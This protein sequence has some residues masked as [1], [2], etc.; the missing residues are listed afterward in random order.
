[1][2]SCLKYY[3]I[4]DKKV[5]VEILKGSCTLSDY[6]DFKSDQINDKDFNPYFN[7]LVDFRGV[8]ITFSGMVEKRLK[9][10]L[11]FSKSI[12]SLSGRKRVAV[13][14]NTPDQVVFFTVCKLLDRRGILYGVFSTE[15]AALHFLS[16]TISEIDLIQC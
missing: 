14:T 15:A 8:D 10:Y 12:V 5:I 13:I 11:E 3:I 6:V 1:M 16:L 7:F 9:L 2:N 4:K